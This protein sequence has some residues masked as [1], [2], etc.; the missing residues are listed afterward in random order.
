[1]CDSRILFAAPCQKRCFLIFLDFLCP[2]PPTQARDD[3]RLITD[4]CGSHAWSAK[5]F[6]TEHL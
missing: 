3:N 6:A 5:V 2:V 1:M 4:V